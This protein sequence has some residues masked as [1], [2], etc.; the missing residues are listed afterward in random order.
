M[1]AAAGVRAGLLAAILAVVLAASALNLLLG[2]L[3]V[4]AWIGLLVL[5]RRVRGVVELMLLATVASGVAAGWLG[6]FGAP[7]PASYADDEA[8]WL[9]RAVVR[10]AGPARPGSGPPLSREAAIR[11]RLA[12]RRREELRYGS[13]ELERRAALAVASALEA[14]RLRDR[15]PVEVAVL[16]DAVRQL[17]LTVTAPEFRDLD[18]RRARLIRWLDELEVRLRMARDPAE[19]SAVARALE[20]TTMAPVSLRALH[21]DLARVNAA[22][23]ALVHKLDRKSVV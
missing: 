15:A 13:G 14:R 17:A 7:A 23:R 4:L 3:W 9:G 19:L 18:T 11:G 22:T 10:V 5:R 8:A 2:G 21:E 20:P 12:E 1:G 6:A 16:D